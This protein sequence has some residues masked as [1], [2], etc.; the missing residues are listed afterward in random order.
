MHPSRAN[1]VWLLLGLGCA[2]RAPLPIPE[3]MDAKSVVVIAAAD[4]ALADFVDLNPGA[5]NRF[6][7]GE[8]PRETVVAY[9]SASLS[10]LGLPSGRQPTASPPAIGLP[11]PVALFDRVRGGAFIDAK[12][13]A[14][15]LFTAFLVPAPALGR[16]Y[17]GGGCYEAGR[18]SVPCPAAPIVAPVAEAAPPDFGAC[19]P[20]W[21]STRVPFELRGQ[22]KTATAC[23][24]I[25]RSCGAGEVSFNGEPCAP[26]DACPGGDWPPI[27]PGPGVRFVAPGGAGDGASP[28]SPLG[29]IAEALRTGA[30]TVAI[31]QGTLQEQLDLTGPLWLV[32][33]CAGGTQL[34]SVAEPLVRIS[35]G[36][37]SISHLSLRGSVAQLRA[38]AGSTL[39]LSAVQIGLNPLTHSLP[40]PLLSSE[41][42]LVMRRVAISGAIFDA[43]EVA[44]GDAD[45]AE[46]L[47]LD[48]GGVPFSV[49][50]R[51]RARIRS[52]WIRGGTLAGIN[53]AGPVD[54]VELHLEEINGK[55]LV[56]DSTALQVEH[57]HLIGGPSSTLGVDASAAQLSLESAWIHGFSGNAVV[58]DHGTTTLREVIISA[59]PGA[60]GTSD[61]V[62][63]QEPHATAEHLL[64]LAAGIGVNFRGL[65]GTQATLS[66]VI[67]PASN[68]EGP[69]DGIEVQGEGELELRRVAISSRHWG[70]AFRHSGAGVARVSDV[71]AEGCLGGL[72]FDLGGSARA[73]VDR[74]ELVDSYQFAVVQIGSPDFPL[75][76]AAVRIYDLEA[77]PSG[78]HGDRP[79][80][81]VI[82]L[83]ERV[84]YDLQRFRV[85][86]GRSAG[87]GLSWPSPHTLKHGLIR[88]SGLSTLLVVLPGEVA[89]QD[90][91]ALYDDVEIRENDAVIRVS[92]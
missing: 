16:C 61:Q 54:A 77:G 55:G 9:F 56:A 67:V 48:S 1:W 2:P 10:E 18:C 50:R 65:A 36:A 69:R 73:E 32:G 80:D 14:P 62:L 43:V 85:S 20:G 7:L 33:A 28:A 19:P 84:P 57:A 38:A 51:A 12:D 53:A 71:Y 26:I 3:V 86:G 47:L 44:A 89:P 68:V 88:G 6:E 76:G 82:N 49:S 11:S 37:V 74:A 27:A 91:G 13:A 8:E 31:S 40:N 64:L 25:P 41:G 72:A 45:V 17:E 52:L 63:L 81:L 29:S 79:S 60:T 15:E 35:G 90:L 58:T 24:P 83:D 4:P 70:I 78:R 34:G 92:D 23:A 39:S 66:D 21:V 46:L 30:A 22:T 42:H 5:I 59:A 87:F 75:M